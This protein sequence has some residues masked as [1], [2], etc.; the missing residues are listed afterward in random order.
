MKKAFLFMV[1]LALSIPMYSQTYNSSCTSTCT[2]ATCPDPEN[3]GEMVP[4]NLPPSTF[5]QVFYQKLDILPPPVASGYQVQW[6]K[7][8]QIQGLPAGLAWATNA[9]QLN[10]GT[11]Y[12]CEVTGTPTGQVGLFNCNVIVD[13]RVRV[14]G[15]WTTQTNQNGGSIMAEVLPAKYNVGGGGS[16]CANPSG[17]PITVSGSNNGT[18]YT[19]Y[20]NGTTTGVTASGNGNAISFPAQTIVG[21][22]TVIAKANFDFDV[23]DT[24]YVTPQPM[25]GVASITQNIPSISLGN[26]QNITITEQTIL[27]AGAGFASYSWNYNN[28]DQ[29]TLTLNGNTLGVG[30]HTII[31]TVTNNEQCSNSDTIIIN[32]TPTLSNEAEITAFTIPNQVGSSVITSTSATTGTVSLTMP[33]GSSHLLTPTIDVSADASVSPNTLVE[34]NFANP[35]VYTVTAEDNVTTKAWT[36]NVTILPNDEAEIT[37]FTI[38]NQV[39]SS[40]ITSTS[41]TTGTVSVTMPYGSSNLLTPTIDVSA[42]ASV[43]PNTLVEQNFSNPVVYTVT[44]EDNVTTKEWTVTVTFLAN[45][46]A[47]ITAFT[48]PNQVGSSVITSTSATTGTVSVTMPYESSNLLTPTIDVSADASVSPNTLV[49]QNFSNPVVYTVTA[50]D[51]VTTK[52]WTVTVTFLANDEAEIT[53]FTI[54]NQV[55]SSVITS[56][57]ATTGTVSVTMP[58]GT[59]TTSLT[60][61]ISLSANASISPETGVPQNFTNPVVYTVTAE[62]N[63]S[64]KAWTVTVN[65]TSSISSND[66]GIEL[67]YNNEN[68]VITLNCKED[69]FNAKIFDIKGQ[70][71]DEF[72]FNCN[73]TYKIPSLPSGI[74]ILKLTGNNKVHTLKFVF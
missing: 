16:L 42:G 27:D 70:L 18:T 46:E 59:N 58:S 14:F 43:S 39:G 25:I 73:Q 55:G 65:V 61:N 54:P 72:I 4:E 7:L 6:I 62:D 30:Q 45:D 13:A 11:W 74:Y 12:C 36:V 33:Y 3:N 10:V 19:L 69:N 64:I 24:N 67:F 57:S 23:N 21:D 38:P 50:E 66:N 48:I 8:K 60:P 20:R 37:A 34:Q 44:A 9:E 51:N 5:G 15:I 56:T 17:L 2:N 35:V 1:M 28:H 53:A 29:Q 32:V 71:I 22:Y 47:E 31:A 41:A 26:D 40:V 63:V 49:E 68:Q 52:A